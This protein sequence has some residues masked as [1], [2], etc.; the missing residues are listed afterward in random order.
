MV[1]QNRE[2]IFPR[3]LGSNFVKKKFFQKARHLPWVVVIYTP[4]EAHTGFRDGVTNAANFLFFLFL[5][6]RAGSA[7]RALAV[8]PVPG[9]RPRGWNRPSKSEQVNQC[10][11]EW[12]RRR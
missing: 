1:D 7:R 8:G 11:H 12:P 10:S 5:A 4:K 2:G 6:R 9:V 3:F